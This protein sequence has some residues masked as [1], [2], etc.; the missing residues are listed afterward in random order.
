MLT[1]SGLDPSQTYELVFY[2]HR[3]GY[4]WDR[5]SLVTI[6]GADVFTNQSSAATDNP[7]AGSGGAI[8]SG[9]G[10]DSTRLPSDND[11]GYVARF[12]G[13][14]PGLDGEVVVTI[15]WEGTPGNEYKGKY[16]NALMLKQEAEGR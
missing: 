16:A 11:N 5:A 3:N 6:S 1:F 9:P 10:D 8:F 15:S 12:T 4:S 13:I 14:D 2:A 7:E